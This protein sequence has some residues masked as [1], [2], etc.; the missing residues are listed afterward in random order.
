MKKLL[1]GTTALVAA[2]M[3]GGVGTAHAQWDVSV[4]GFMNQWFGYGDNDSDVNL[5]DPI[6]DVDNI[7]GDPN[8]WNQWSN[9]EIHFNFSNTLDNGLRFGGR[10]ELEGETDTD[11]IDEQYLFVDGD[12]GRILLG[13]ENSAGYLM[14]ITSPNVGLPINSGS[15]YNHIVEVF[16]FADARFRS[17]LG[18]TQIEPAG[19]NDSN[20][21]TYFTPRLSG[22]QFGISYLPD[23]FQDQA[24][25]TPANKDVEYTNGV[26]VGVN[27]VENLFGIDVAASFGYYYMTAPEFEDTVLPTVDACTIVNPF[28]GATFDRCDDFQG[29]NAGVNFGYGGFTVGASYAEIFDGVVALDDY[30]GIAV[31]TSTEGFAVEGGIS[32]ET[33]PWGASVNAF[34]GQNEGVVFAGGYNENLAVQGSLAY[35]L[36]PGVRILGSVGW[37]EY[38]GQ[39][40]PPE[41]HGVAGRGTVRAENEGVYATTG[42]ALSF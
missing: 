29:I 22:F 4:N 37:A 32:Y 25:D 3:I 6:P 12:F 8:D 24:A 35:T 40:V 23:T 18:S 33:G 36:G 41:I 11:Q 21:I 14:T 39:E 9:T 19:A 5:V 34:Y 2:G 10:V 7:I 16:Q 30:D 26:S 15:Q 13:S 20:K 38:Q 28:S 17:V 42:V 1:Y 27:Y 31:I